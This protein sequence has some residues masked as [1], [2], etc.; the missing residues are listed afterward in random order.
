M[1][2]DVHLN[3]KTEQKQTN[4]VMKAKSCQ[5][6]TKQSDWLT[7]HSRDRCWDRIVRQILRKGPQWDRQKDERQWSWINT[8]HNRRNLNTP[9]FL[10]VPLFE[11]QCFRHTGVIW[12][13]QFL[14]KR[15]SHVWKVSLISHDQ[16]LVEKMLKRHYFI[17]TVHE[18]KHSHELNSELGFCL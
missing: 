11:T 12:E 10:S 4:F 17:D 6:L 14:R 18:E 15:W 1:S 5:K 16:Y 3:K 9:S 13:P 7:H 2:S 8:K